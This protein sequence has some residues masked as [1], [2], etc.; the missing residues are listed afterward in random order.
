MQIEMVTTER[1]SAYMHLMTPDEFYAI[2]DDRLTCM[3]VYDEKANTPA[4][5]ITLKVLPDHIRIVRLFTE[6]SY[7]QKGVASTLL[8]IATD[9]SGGERPDYYFILSDGEADTDFMARRGFAPEAGKYSFITGRIRDLETFRS[10]DEDKADF[11]VT[12]AEEV[13]ADALSRFVFGMEHDNFLQFPEGYVDM[14]RFSEG[15]IICQGVGGVKGAMMIEEMEDYIQVT[16]VGASEER[17]FGPLFATLYREYIKE[18]GLDAQI[19]FLACS[20]NEKEVLSKVFV[21]SEELPVSVYKLTNA[22]NY[23]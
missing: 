3:G 17:F 1:L 19:R 16:W 20:P 22:F 6:P 5:V 21:R 18:Y 13:D 14:D 7:R 12:S 8:E 15:S 23:R 11:S 10:A 2:T 4:G 9:I